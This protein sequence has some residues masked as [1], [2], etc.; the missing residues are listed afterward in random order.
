MEIAEYLDKKTVGEWG[1]IGQNGVA[2]LEIMGGTKPS[3]TDYAVRIA[4]TNDTPGSKPKKLSAAGEG[5]ALKAPSVKIDKK[6]NNAKSIQ[7]KK[8]QTYKMGSTAKP[9]TDKFTLKVTTGNEITLWTT[10]TAK[11]PAS[12]PIT[13]TI[14]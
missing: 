12:E 10:A 7:L 1:T 13:F 6:A 5:K 14:D 2:V 8:G 11:K 9:L 3:K 4:P